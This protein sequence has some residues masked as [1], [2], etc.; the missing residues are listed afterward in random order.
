MKSLSLVLVFAALASGSPNDVWKQPATGK[1][2]FEIVS[3]KPLEVTHKSPFLCLRITNTSPK[4]IE[5]WSAGFWPNHT[6]KV[7]NLKGV[8]IQPTEQGR[9]RLKIFGSTERD[10]N[11]KFIVEPGKK[12]EYATPSLLGDFDLKAGIQYR[13]EIAYS[14]ACDKNHL[15]LRTMPTVFQVASS[16]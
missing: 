1:I 11:A 9:T 15:V 7:T 16:N 12:L 3:K 2:A 13:V 6:W 8:P 10:K 14:D 4:P 5:V